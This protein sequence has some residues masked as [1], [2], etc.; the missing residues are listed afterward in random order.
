MIPELIEEYDFKELNSYE[1][2]YHF[3]IKFQIENES[4]TFSDKK[5]KYVRNRKSVNIDL[6][7][8][9]GT[10]ISISKFDEESLPVKKA[11]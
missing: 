9:K 7:D 8:K 3:L 1:F 11:V 4:K 10:I 2:V 6:K 5:I